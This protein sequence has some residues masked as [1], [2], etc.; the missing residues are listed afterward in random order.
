MFAAKCIAAQTA[1]FGQSIAERGIFPWPQTPG[2]IGFHFIP[3]FQFAQLANYRRGVNDRQE[4]Q[5]DKHQIFAGYLQI[6]RST[7]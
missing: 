3:V 7:N 5:K 4:R 6:E 1:N 2:F